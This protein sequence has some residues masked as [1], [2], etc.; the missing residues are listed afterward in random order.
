MLS[1]TFHPYLR[2]TFQGILVRAFILRCIVWLRTIVFQCN[3]GLWLRR[4][5][6][7]LF[8]LSFLPHPSTGSAVG[9]DLTDRTSSLHMCLWL[10]AEC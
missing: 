7:P 9:F 3:F 2:P 4:H 5:S 1:S 8:L 10:F 6:R